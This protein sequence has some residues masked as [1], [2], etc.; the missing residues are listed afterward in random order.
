VSHIYAWER[1]EMSTKFSSENLK[2]RNHPD[3]LVVDGEDNIKM[4]S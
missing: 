3:E 1:Q 2:G 4:S